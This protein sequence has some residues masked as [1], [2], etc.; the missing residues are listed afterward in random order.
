MN[1]HS[2]NKP[3]ACIALLLLLCSSFGVRAQHSNHFFREKT[4]SLEGEYTVSFRTSERH[5]RYVLSIDSVQGACFYGTL[6]ADTAL[7]K[8]L[9]D[10]VHVKGMIAGHRNYDFIMKPMFNKGIPYTL[11]CIP[12][13]WLFNNKVYFSRKENNRLVGYMV[14]CNERAPYTFNFYGMK[15]PDEVSPPYLAVRHR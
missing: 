10:F 4:D 8:T 1:R 3:G 13:D 12:S 14:V 15:R 11:G 6:R 7:Y 9:R 5:F 2:N